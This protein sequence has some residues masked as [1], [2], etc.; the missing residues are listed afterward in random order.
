[1]MRRGTRFDADQARR[2]LLKKRQ[3]VAPLQS[4][5]ND[6]LPNS[7]NAVDLKDRLRDIET[8]CRD[9]SAWIAPPICGSLNST[10]FFGT[11]V[12]VEEPSTAS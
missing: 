10:H 6:H 3:N 2:Q 4:T 12:P 8:D 1:M 7:I 9:R 5:P 11:Y